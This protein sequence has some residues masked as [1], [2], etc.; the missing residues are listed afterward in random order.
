MRFDLAMHGQRL[1][2]EFCVVNAPSH[3][4]KVDGL[5]TV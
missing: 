5:P 3:M 2:Q 4:M 1:K